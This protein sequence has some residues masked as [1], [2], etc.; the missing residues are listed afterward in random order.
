MKPYKIIALMLIT[1]LAAC[2]SNPE[3]K[4]FEGKKGEVKLIVLD[5]GHFHADL[6][7]KQ[8]SERID[9]NI[10]VYAPKGIELD[11]FLTRVKSFN[12]RL[13]SPTNWN[14]M[15]ETS[16]DFLQQMLT[17]KKGNVVLIS[18]NNQRKTDYIYQSIAAGLNVLADKPMAIN[19]DNFELLKKAFILAEKNKVMLFDIMTERYDILNI[20]QQEI[21]QD[22]KLFGT[23]QADSPSDPS[24]KVESVHH[25]YKT[26]AGN[27]LIRPAWYYDVEQQGEGIVDVTTHLIDLVNWKCFPTTVVD[28]KKDIAVISAS[29]WPTMLSL[30]QYERSTGM[31]HFPAYLD[32]DI[33]DG[34][35]AVHSNGEVVY[36]I[37]DLH[38]AMSVI[39]NYEAPAGSKDTHT[40]II[41][42]TG[43]IVEIIQNEATAYAPKLYISQA[44]DVTL[45]AFTTALNNFMT[46]IQVKYPDLTFSIEGNKY[47][48]NVPEIYN[49]GHESHF[50]KVADAYFDFLVKGQMPEWETAAMLAKYYIT[51]TAM[52]MANEK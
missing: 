36:R 37:K 49:E 14:L 28:Y 35:L 41:K 15:E 38:V 6:L 32:K 4:S 20:L 13:E 40:S 29:H 19:P 7:F 11:Q 52:K 39:W 2:Q 45:E 30:E 46:K 51:T 31:D 33:K 44:K 27:P 42:G 12:N 10:F 50:T 22:E 16:E 23:T 1:V 18:G 48:I 34:V 9:T 47:C 24:I 5:P 26:V 21:M 43:A 3:N 17:N 8:S 25:F